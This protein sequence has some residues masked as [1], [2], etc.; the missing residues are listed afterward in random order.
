MHLLTMAIWDP[1]REPATRDPATH[2]SNIHVDLVSVGNRRYPHAPRVHEPS[3]SPR[4][5][6][7][8]AALTIFAVPVMPA[9]QQPPPLHCPA[10]APVRV[11][12]LF[13]GSG[14]AASRKTPGL[15]WSHN[16]SGKPVVFALDGKDMTGRLSAAR[17]DRR[18]L[19]SG[20]GGIVPIRILPLCG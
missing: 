14:L 13:E 16:D 1:K 9:A 7:A 17:C 11:K 2:S 6:E 8:L 15:F 18:R 19:G 4:R 12:E 20:R 10:A 5:M 3:S